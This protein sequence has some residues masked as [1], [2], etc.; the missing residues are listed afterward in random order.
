MRIFRNTYE[1][2]KKK[3]DSKKQRHIMLMI[4]SH[5]ASSLA[6]VVSWHSKS[7]FHILFG[8]YWIFLAI[9]NFFF[10]FVFI[11]KMKQ[12]RTKKKK[13][14]I[15]TDIKFWCFF[16]YS[17]LKKNKLPRRFDREITATAAAA[18]KFTFKYEVLRWRYCW[19]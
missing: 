5:S 17:F 16:F 1:C 2:D 7:K 11:W 3:L 10:H 18:I 6:L 8:L 4:L 13:Q 19:R 14:S 15:Q 12:K 9:H